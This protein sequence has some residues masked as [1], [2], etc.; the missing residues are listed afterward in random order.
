VLK[1]AVSNL[2]GNICV[3]E[4][5]S[6]VNLEGLMSFAERMSAS[7]TK[8]P[9]TSRTVNRKLGFKE[10]NLPKRFGSSRWRSTM[11]FTV[12]TEDPSA[13]DVG[14][15][16]IMG[17]IDALGQLNQNFV[18]SVADAGDTQENEPVRQSNVDD[19]DADA[20]DEDDEEDDESDP[21]A[22]DDDTESERA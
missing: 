14:D 11:A 12:L 5:R 17:N 21:E 15:L 7:D 16:I 1:T 2:T 9:L 13:R 19:A 22:E 10:V 3:V 6:A 4:Q 20:D 18:D 8:S